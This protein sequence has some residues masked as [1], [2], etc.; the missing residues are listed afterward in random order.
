MINFTE[1]KQKLAPK[2]KKVLFDIGSSILTEDIGTNAYAGFIGNQDETPSSLG[3]KMYS[4]TIYTHPD[5]PGKVFHFSGTNK[6]I[7]FDS[8]H[9]AIEH[10]DMITKANHRELESMSSDLQR[11]Y[12]PALYSDDHAVALKQYTHA[13]SNLNYKLLKGHN[14]LTGDKHTMKHLDSAINKQHSPDNMILWSGAD[15]DHSE[16]LQRENVV[17]HPSYIS[18]SISPKIAMGFAVEKGGDLIKIH[19]P[20]GHPGIFIPPHMSSIPSEKEFIL[21]RNLR[22]RVDHSKRQRFVHDMHKQ[23]SGFIHHVFVEG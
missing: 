2:T 16:T 10:D 14:L 19:L 21:P 13:M 22:L 3:Y 11:H 1:Y 17:H 4:G 6:P 7:S 15:A 20:A 23:R 8:I 12:R 9:D 5:H 18:T